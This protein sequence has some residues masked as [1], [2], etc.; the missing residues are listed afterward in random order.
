MFRYTLDEL[1]ENM[2]R[3]HESNGPLDDLYSKQE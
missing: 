1:L 2:L 3:N